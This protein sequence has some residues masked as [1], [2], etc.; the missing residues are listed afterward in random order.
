[1]ER[2]LAEGA[3]VSYGAFTS[4]VH[5][6]GGTTHGVWW[7]APSIAGIMRVRDELLQQ[8]P[9]PAM[10]AATG[11]RDYF[12]RS[13]IHRSRSVS[14][15]SGYVWVSYN[16]VQPGKAREWRELWEKYTKPVFDELLANGT[17]SMYEVQVEQ[18]HTDD[19]G[20]RFVVYVA[21][22]ADAADKVRAAFAALSQKRGEVETRAIAG[23][24]AD[25]TVPGTHRDFFA[26]VVIY[27]TK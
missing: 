13:L 24:F 26:Q 10:V 11:H 15:T 16:Q 25:V 5:E 1:L 22:S 17:F 6:T 20:G 14:P 4:I 8:P 3:L 27:A 19:P 21:P 2:L 23:A 18:V 7:E 12:L 9:N